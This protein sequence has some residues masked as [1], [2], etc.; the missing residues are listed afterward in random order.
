M[1]VKTACYEYVSVKY[2]VSRNAVAVVVATLKRR[3]ER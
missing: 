1:R 2:Q 3:I